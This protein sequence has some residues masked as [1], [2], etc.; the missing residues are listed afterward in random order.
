MT[1][2]VAT[3]T[4]LKLCLHPSTQEA[5]QTPKRLQIEE[6]NRKKR[7]QQVRK[8]TPLRYPTRRRLSLAAAMTV[9][10]AVYNIGQVSSFATTSISSSTSKFT[11]S[12][13]T[14]PRERSCADS[15]SSALYYKHGNDDD[16]GFDKDNSILATRIDQMKLSVLEE[17]IRRPPNP[18]LSPEQL[19]REV[20]DALLNSYDPLPD[21]G[22]RMLLRASTDEWRTKILQSIGAPIKPLSQ[23]NGNKTDED[24]KNLNIDLDLVA[25]ALGEAMGR[26]QNQF[27][28]LVGEEEEYQLDFPSDPLEY[29][30]DGTCWIE[31]HIRSSKNDANPGKLLVITGWELKKLGDDGSWLVDGIIWQDFREKYRPG[32]GREEWTRIC[33]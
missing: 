12:A 18:N 15:S 29:A 24:N 14:S 13:T 11:S 20:F 26:P 28:I 1:L 27:A 32:I 23:T 30:D 33:R 2:F 16:S 6:V 7:Q 8:M 31:C 10:A 25:S 9:V 3:S 21:A 19:V 5:A 17:E 4:C 22:F